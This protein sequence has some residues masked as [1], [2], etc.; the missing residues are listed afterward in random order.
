MRKKRNGNYSWL[1]NAGDRLYGVKRKRLRCLFWKW[2]TGDT[3]PHISSFR[4]SRLK[5][6]I[7]LQCK[8]HFGFSDAS[9]PTWFFF[10]SP[11]FIDGLSY[12]REKIPSVYQFNNFPSRSSL[13]PRWFLNL[14]WHYLTLV[15]FGS[16]FFLRGKFFFE[17]W[18]KL[19]RIPRI[20][21]RRV[22]NRGSSG[23]GRRGKEKWNFFRRKYFNKQDFNEECFFPASIFKKIFHKMNLIWMFIS[24]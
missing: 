12:T 21:E 20:R 6:R 1:I 8:Y 7:S 23:K 22:K 2:V 11:I 13:P 18:I 5:T 19:N 15:L 24:R 10:L 4:S 16:Y 3:P 9:L 17:K 14:S